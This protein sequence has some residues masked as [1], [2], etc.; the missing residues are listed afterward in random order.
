MQA[1][2]AAEADT[3][4]GPRERKPSKRMNRG[5][6]RDFAFALVEDEVRS[7]R[8]AREIIAPGNCRP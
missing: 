7:A 2:D 8:S 1:R 5:R 4:V 3:A 6:R